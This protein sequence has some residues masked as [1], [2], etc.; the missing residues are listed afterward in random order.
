MKAQAYLQNIDI[1]IYSL[2]IENKTTNKNNHLFYSSK[3]EETK[4]EMY[5]Y[6]FFLK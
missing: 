2:Y 1:Y 4:R 5:I 6:I 3:K